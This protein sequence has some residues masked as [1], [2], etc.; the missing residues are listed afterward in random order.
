M[1]EWGLWHIYL[2]FEHAIQVCENNR[3][4][5]T[6]GTLTPL[7]KSL[8]LLS[9]EAYSLSVDNNITAAAELEKKED[10]YSNKDITTSNFE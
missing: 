10:V 4:T 2:S 5:K 9:N 1:A 6:S 3:L 8:R 7:K